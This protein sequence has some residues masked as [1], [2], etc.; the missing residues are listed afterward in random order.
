VVE[1]ETIGSMVLV[2]GEEIHPPHQ[3]QILHM[4]V[5]VMVPIKIHHLLQ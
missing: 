1:E 5:E 3:L 4:L 2:E